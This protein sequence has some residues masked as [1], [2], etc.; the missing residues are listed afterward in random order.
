MK[1]FIKIM[2]AATLAMALSSCGGK[3]KA[4][5]TNE[6]DT[7][8][9]T[10]ETTDNEETVEDEV[11][12]EE[13]Q[14]DSNDTLVDGIY[15]AE[16]KEFDSSDYKTIVT[17]AVTD[18]KISELVIDAYKEDGT[19]KRSA[20]ESGEYDMSVA[21]SEKTWT[22]QADLFAEYIIS[23]QETSVEVD[24][25]GKTDA[26]SGVTI[27]I[28]GYMNLV[29]E[30]LASEPVT[31]ELE[32]GNDEVTLNPGS[33]TVEADGFDSST[34]FKDTLTLIVDENGM[35]SE[36]IIDAYKEDGTT[37]RSAVENGEYD[38]SV[39]GSEKT[40]TEQADLFAEYVVANQSNSVAM[41]DEGKT[42]A[43]SGVTIS[44]RGYVRLLDDALTLAE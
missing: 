7:V 9:E 44:V 40:W 31:A 19:T 43:V 30:A 11:K 32:V 12:E 35:I 28:D 21:G 34:G 13:E 3:D 41:D 39:A 27:S 24:G 15:F 8:Q 38:M 16:E 25:E 29:N 22:E 1:K 6:P 18:G 20:V 5:S 36:V 14:V 26:V 42:D 37:K 4:V 33:Y 23:T 10:N 2:L 17:I